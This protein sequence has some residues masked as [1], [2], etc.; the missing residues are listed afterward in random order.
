VNKIEVIT[1]PANP[2]VKEIRRTAG[3]GCETRDGFV[4]AESFH[5]LDEALGDECEIG[6]VIASE[7]ARAGVE[8]RLAGFPAIRLVV[9]EERLFAT[10]STTEAT[11][12]VITLVRPPA[13]SIEQF[14][15][16]QAA[17]IVV[18]D[19]VQDP[20]NAG[21]IVRAAEAFGATGMLFLKG[22][23]NP[24]NPKAV[25]A[26]AGS[27][28]RMPVLAGM[29]AAEARAA[30]VERGV[31]IYAAMPS[32]A[33]DLTDAA[34]DRPCALVIGSES[35]GVGEEFRRGAAG[36][37]IPIARVESLNAAMAAGILL[38]EARRQRTLKGNRG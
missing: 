32:G 22:S 18:L 25:R 26:S 24:N 17:L 1:S 28:F 27:L 10:V 11:Q 3:R 7:S 15:G 4:I 23:A 30:L 16:V 36:L 20:G 12:G 19:G 34:L 5:L 33:C 29:E 6:A 35:R 2:L 21:A 31:E 38:Y 13:W 14:F 37:R 8:E 9:L